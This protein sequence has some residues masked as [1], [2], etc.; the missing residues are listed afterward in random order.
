MLFPQLVTV[1]HKYNLHITSTWKNKQN[2]I[3]VNKDPSKW[4]QSHHCLDL[5]RGAPAQTAHRPR[6]NVPPAAVASS[7][8]SSPFSRHT[9]TQTIGTPWIQFQT[10]LHKKH[11]IQRP[12]KPDL[13]TWSLNCVFR[14][15]LFLC[16]QDLFQRA[17]WG[18]HE[19]SGCGQGVTSLQSH[20]Y[21][22]PPGP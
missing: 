20:T 10:P 11:V 16:E 21:I 22:S 4:L 18:K 2:Y 5:D 8:C 3:N 15:P 6:A 17:R 12:F 9:Q 14:I 1:V 13:V 19:T 7:V